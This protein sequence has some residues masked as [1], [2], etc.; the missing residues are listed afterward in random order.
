[1]SHPAGKVK[2]TVVGES[3]ATLADDTMISR[4]AP[5]ARR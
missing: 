4:A 1:M 2:I 5:P 3:G